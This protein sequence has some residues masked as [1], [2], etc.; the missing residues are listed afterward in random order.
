MAA[1]PPDVRFNLSFLAA[2]M[3]PDFVCTGGI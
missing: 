2:W 1:L 3:L